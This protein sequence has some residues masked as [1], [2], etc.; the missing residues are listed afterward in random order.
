MAE[1]TTE[2]L[3]RLLRSIRK[4]LAKLDAKLAKACQGENGKTVIT[5]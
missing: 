1:A 4:R 5:M 3:L 2:H